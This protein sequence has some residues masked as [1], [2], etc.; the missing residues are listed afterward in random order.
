V[1]FFGQIERDVGNFVMHDRLRRD[2][3]VRGDL[4]APAEPNARSLLKRSLY[5]DLK[6]AGA[7]L[8]SFVGN[9]DPIRDNHEL[10]Q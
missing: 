5:G 6:P 9:G 7:R 3:G 8:S 2:L 1:V 10:R 4:S